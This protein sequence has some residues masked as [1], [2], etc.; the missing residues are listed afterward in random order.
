MSQVAIQNY[1]GRDYTVPFVSGNDPLSVT[2]VVLKTGLN[3][4]TGE[5]WDKIKSHPCV[6]TLLDTPHDYCLMRRKQ[7]EGDE[8]DNKFLTTRETFNINNETHRKLEVRDFRSVDASPQTR[9]KD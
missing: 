5:V 1:I 6:K 9:K 7:V 3:I 2:N 8:K 4:L